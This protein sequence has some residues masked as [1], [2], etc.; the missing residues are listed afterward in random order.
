[1]FSSCS[2]AIITAPPN[3]D[4]ELLSENESGSVIKYKKCW[5]L[6]WGFV[7]ITDNSTTDVI[8]QYNLKSVKATTYYSFIDFII[9]FFLSWTTLHT[10][11]IEIEGNVGK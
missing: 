9:S 7:P 6:L 2:T 11:T 8:A 3:K 10:M 5:Y 4:V 1:M